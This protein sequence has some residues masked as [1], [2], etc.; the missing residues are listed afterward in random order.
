MVHRYYYDGSTPAARETYRYRKQAG[1]KLILDTSRAEVT[2]FV[3]LTGDPSGPMAYADNDGQVDVRVTDR[4]GRDWFWYRAAEGD[5][6]V[7]GKE[8]YRPSQE[9]QGTGILKPLDL[10]RHEYLEFLPWYVWMLEP[11]LLAGRWGLAGWNGLNYEAGLRLLGPMASLPM[12]E[13]E[14]KPAFRRRRLSTTACWAKGN[15]SGSVKG[16][17]SLGNESCCRPL[18]S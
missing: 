5:L 3:P 16:F 15:W 2:R 14:L 10:P 9:M 18:Q 8:V 11:E 7:P 6:V 1:D 12:R 17:C 4:Y 13:R